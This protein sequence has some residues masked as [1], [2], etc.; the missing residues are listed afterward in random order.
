MTANAYT[1]KHYPARS[2]YFVTPN[3]RNNVYG[4]YY[5][6]DFPKAT[7]R[8]CCQLCARFFN[9]LLAGAERGTLLAIID[10][11]RSL[12]PVQYRA[13]VLDLTARLPEK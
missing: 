9:G 3:V 6:A 2:A 7:A 8:E 1:A 13:L 11:L 10:R 4:F 12:L 5:K